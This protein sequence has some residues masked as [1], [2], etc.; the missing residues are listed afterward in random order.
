MSEGF[1]P[2]EHIGK[3]LPPMTVVIERGPVSNFATAITDTNP[4]YHNADKA[5]AAGF[6]NIPA[7]PTWGF[8]MLNWGRFP[9]V[10]PE[11]AKDVS[12]VMFAIG[13]LMQT[14]GMILHGEE[15]FIYHRPIVVGDKLTSSGKIR[16]IYAK[17]GKSTMTFVVTETHWRDEAGDPVLSETMT[18]I[19]R[20]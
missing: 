3:D 18:L 2:T 13:G 17:E 19:H 15:E 16:D 6:D 9:E 1:D 7:P 4:I 20:A 10:Q 12:P 5:R 8:G 14:G 11:G